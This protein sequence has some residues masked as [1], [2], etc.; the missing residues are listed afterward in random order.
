MVELAR[1]DIA[2]VKVLNRLS[3]TLTGALLVCLLSV[4]MVQ[5]SV[6][7]ARAPSWRC[8]ERSRILNGGSNGYPQFVILIFNSADSP[9][10]S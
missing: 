4:N 3:L 5:A 2:P 7:T 8:L 9:T 10:R 1:C 6:I